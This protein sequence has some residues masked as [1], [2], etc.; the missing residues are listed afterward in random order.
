MTAEWL[1][2]VIDEKLIE[3][4]EIAGACDEGLS[5]LRKQPRTFGEMRNYKLSWLQWMADNLR[6]SAVLEKLAGDAHYGVRCGVASNANTPVAVLEK[7]AGDAD[8]DVRCG[9]ASNANTPVAV[10]EKLAGDADHDVRWRVASNANTPVAVLE[11]R[12]GDA[13]YGVRREAKKSL[14]ALLVAAK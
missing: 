14:Q 11:K 5:W 10:L 12:A 8:N 7:L 13:D 6:D 1:G 9:V 4:C 2:E 3:A